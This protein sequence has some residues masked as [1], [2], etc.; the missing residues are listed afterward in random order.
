MFVKWIKNG[1]REFIRDSKEKILLLPSLWNISVWNK[2]KALQYI[3]SC[4][5]INKG[6]MLDNTILV[7]VATLVKLAESYYLEST[8]TWINYKKNSMKEP[9]SFPLVYRLTDLRL[10][11]L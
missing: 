10:E 1:G 4:S 5:N 6:A 3:R 11:K 9:D 2:I 7:T 8:N